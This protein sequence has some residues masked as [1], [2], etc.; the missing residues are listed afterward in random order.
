M[1]KRKMFSIWF[2]KWFVGVF[3]LLNP[4][5]LFAQ[6]EYAI[7]HSGDGMYFKA[8]S[9][10]W[11]P[12]TIDIELGVGD[13]LWTDY[14]QYLELLCMYKGKAYT[15]F[16]EGNTKMQLRKKCGKAPSHKMFWGR[17]RIGK[18]GMLGNWLF[19]NPYPPDGIGAS[20]SDGP[21]KLTIL[22]PRRGRVLSSRP[23]L[24]WVLGKE[25]ELPLQISM[26]DEQGSEVFVIVSVLDSV[27]IVYPAHLDSL[28][29]G[30]GYFIEM[31]SASDSSVPSSAKASFSI[32]GS[33]A[34]SNVENQRIT[35]LNSFSDPLLGKLA[36]VGY[37]LDTAYYTEAYLE[38]VELN[39]E[40][41]LVK[42]M[43]AQY[44][45][46]VGLDIL[47]PGLE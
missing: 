39:Q 27:S 40:S 7:W 15:I 3:T 10:K 29:T 16:L 21:E 35:I 1:R 23:E 45:L 38:L 33:L 43:V 13:S 31:K 30:K 12:M 5:Q 4:L 14:G 28:P 8:D 44:Y 36:Y 47:I 26:L 34:R 46:A 32:V 20:R 6:D 41:P 25:S 19:R 42:R 37:L 11:H 24:R 2:L 9:M 18:I 22:T 17:D